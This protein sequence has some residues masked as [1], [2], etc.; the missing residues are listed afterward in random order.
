MK[1]DA[2]YAQKIADAIITQLKKG[3]APWQKP[4]DGRGFLPYNPIS[5]VTYK[6]SNTLYLLAQQENK[7][8][9]DNRWMTYD[10]ASGVDAQVRKGEKGTQ[11]RYWQW[12]QERKVLDAQGRPVKDAEG[13]EVRQVVK[14]DYPL[15]R[16][17]TVFNASQIEGLPASLTRA[18]NNEWELHERAEGILSNSGAVIKHKLGNAAYYSPKLDA[19]VLPEKSQF[20]EQDLYYGVALHELGHWTGHEDRL[21]RDLSN[22]FGSPGY[23]REELRAEIASLILADELGIRYDPEQ[24]VAYIGS[25]IKALEEDPTEI[26]RASAEAQKIG[27]YIMQFDPL[28]QKQQQQQSADTAQ[29]F[30]D[31]M[32]EGRSCVFDEDAY[33]D[34]LKLMT[35]R[36][37][38]RDAGWTASQ[39]ESE[40]KMLGSIWTAEEITPA[41]ASVMLSNAQK[42]GNWTEALGTEFGFDQA[43]LDAAALLRGGDYQQGTIL[44]DKGQA[45]AE[46]ASVIYDALKSTT[47]SERPA[48]FVPQSERANPIAR[49]AMQG[50]KPWSHL[51]DTLAIDALSRNPVTPE[52]SI[53]VA[54][55]GVADKD[56]PIVVPFEEKDHAK[57][58]GAKWHKAEKTWYVP[59]GSALGPFARWLPAQAEDVVQSPAQTS[60]ERVYLS[61]P[62]EDRNAAKAQG[63]KW[64]KDAKSW[65]VPTGTDEAPFAQ[66]MRGQAGESSI[67][68]VDEFA[69]AL[70]VAGFRLDAA[71]K[72]DGALHRVP[73]EGDTGRER[74][75]AYR[76]Y[77]DGRPAGWFENHKTGEKQNWKAS[78][79][80]SITEAER[81]ELIANAAR[82]REIR[83]QAEA[84]KHQQAA[85][86]ATALLSVATPASA[87]HPYLVSKGV[88]PHGLLQAT[89]ATVAVADSHLG[90]KNHSIRDGDLLLPMQRRDGDVRSLQ[91]IKADGWKGF[92]PGG[93][94]VGLYAMIGDPQASKQG[95]PQ[96]IAE[97]Y[98]TAAS[99]HDA[100]TDPVA[101]AFNASNLVAVAKELREQSPDASLYIAGDDDRHLPLKTPPRP[102][103]GQQKAEEAAKQSNGLAILPAFG[104]AQEGI[105]WNDVAQREGL[106]GL[107]RELDASVARAEVRAA[108]ERQ[109]H[110][111]GL[112]STMSMTENQS[113]EVQDAIT[114]FRDMKGISSHVSRDSINAASQEAAQQSVQAQSVRESGS[115]QKMG[116][117]ISR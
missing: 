115:S 116:R 96:W 39:I 102:N 2:D 46:F 58:R 68:P 25:W 89:A 9:S 45:E 4:W 7:G 60:D 79:K 34:A 36:I 38:G 52:P 84:Q 91:V 97:G 22:P 72:M 10:Q 6:G 18:V 100:T 63:A 113:A 98:A 40:A 41:A 99:V 87:D 26:L 66:W 106:Q 105:D 31:R 88:K 83:E 57:A 78:A 55:M 95:R 35:D 51:I 104:P 110:G 15:V 80:S 90:E 3:T 19:I 54:D 56:T 67:A 33:D 85:G 24:N 74:S 27:A 5:G 42:V 81:R 14:L 44:A 108:R 64:D 69:E 1:N 117:R 77:T 111:I 103:V 23:A 109:D 94:V 65:Y 17:F 11:L 82:S 93:Q 43:A 49:N 92:L 101:V 21:A 75:G 20:A 28:R 70:R 47:S 71:P 61:V 12:T 112:A 29:A 16:A 30:Q 53:D 37:L 48:W 114:A 76:A 107:V 32:A 13:K 73:V 8:Y 50:E 62:W 59:E 86:I